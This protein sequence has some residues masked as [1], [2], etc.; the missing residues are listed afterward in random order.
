MQETSGETGPIL[1]E[2]VD[3]IGLMKIQILINALKV[4]DTI[5]K[6][7]PGSGSDYKELSPAFKQFLKEGE[8]PKLVDDEGTNSKI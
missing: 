5:P 7:E 1:I 6:P 2:G 8:L 3:K 4:N